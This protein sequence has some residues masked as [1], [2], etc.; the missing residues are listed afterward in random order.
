MEKECL[1]PSERDELAGKVIRTLD[2]IRYMEAAQILD[3]AKHRLLDTSRVVAES[4]A[5]DPVYS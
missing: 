1:T 3:Y 5:K 2:G 4:A